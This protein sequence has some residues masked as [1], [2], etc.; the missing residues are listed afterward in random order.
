MV[1]SES[2]PKG[3]QRKLCDGA[4]L[5]VRVTLQVVGIVCQ[6]Q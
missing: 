6:C 5:V 3:V 4:V 1:A 2:C